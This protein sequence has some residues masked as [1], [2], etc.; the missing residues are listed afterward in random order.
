[1][2]KL[3]P[4]FLVHVAVAFQALNAPIV[5]ACVQLQPLGTVGQDGLNGGLTVVPPVENSDRDTEGSIR[6]EWIAYTISR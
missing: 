2:P 6:A 1:M 3:T 5:Y 4:P